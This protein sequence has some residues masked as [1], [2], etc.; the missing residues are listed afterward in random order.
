MIFSKNFSKIL[1][2]G[3][4]GFGGMPVTCTCTSPPAAADVQ[5]EL[6]ADGVG[7]FFLKSQELKQEKKMGEI[8]PITECSSV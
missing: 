3:W 7:K 8:N 4:G 6:K 1:R 2:P 5:H